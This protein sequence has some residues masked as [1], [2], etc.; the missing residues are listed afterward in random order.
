MENILKEACTRRGAT[1]R[2]Q[3]PK[4]S[5]PQGGCNQHQWKAEYEA[6]P[7]TAQGSADRIQKVESY[8]QLFNAIFFAR[9]REVES[10]IENTDEELWTLAGV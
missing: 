4:P 7:H 2:N 5:K 6:E 9:I 1:T 3:M 10:R 8:L